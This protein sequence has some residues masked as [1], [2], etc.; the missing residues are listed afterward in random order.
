M[1][2]VVQVVAG[3]TRAGADRLVVVPSPSCAVMLLPQHHRLPSVRDAHVESSLAET[4]GQ[5]LASPTRI[6]V[7]CK[8]PLIPSCPYPFSPKPHGVW[9]V[10]VRRCER[11]P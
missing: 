7:D 8:V 3:P 6:G 5:V 9:S 1:K 11:I 2:P 10:R 4:L